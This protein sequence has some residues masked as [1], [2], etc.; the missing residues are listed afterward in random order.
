MRKG[1]VGAQGIG[2]WALRSKW[3]EKPK[4]R[5]KEVSKPGRG[6]ALYTM[7]SMCRPPNLIF[8]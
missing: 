2:E 4:E 8:Y 6:D 7:D 1:Q 5:E 3:L